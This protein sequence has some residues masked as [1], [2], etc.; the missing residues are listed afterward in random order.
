MGLQTMQSIV[1]DGQ[2]FSSAR[3]L[4][5]SATAPLHARVD[6]FMSALLQ[7]RV[8][9]Y[10]QFLA[11]SAEA[12]FPLELALGKAGVS[13]ILA[14]WPQRS[15]AAALHADLRALSLTAPAA[16]S[17]SN[18]SIFCDEASMFG[19]VYVLEGSRLGAT[20]IHRLLR[21]AS[22]GKSQDALSYLTHGQG[23]QLWPTFL[24]ELEA[25]DAVRHRPEAAIAGAIT[26]FETFLPRDKTAPQESQFHI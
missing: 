20:V 23:M 16:T 1:V 19:A 22:S 17:P 10:E 14:D 9:G 12:I 4:L 13:S 15:R 18:A 3:G 5:Q 6:R 2:E 21:E 7:Q 25:S 8:G 24:Q 11:H 26:A